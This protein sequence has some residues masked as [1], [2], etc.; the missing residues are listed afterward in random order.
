MFLA[1]GALAVI[2]KTSDEGN[3][4]VTVDRVESIH[5]T[6]EIAQVYFRKI[7]KAAVFESKEMSCLK[8]AKTIRS[9]DQARVT[10]VGRSIIGLEVGDKVLISKQAEIKRT[11]VVFGSAA[12]LCMLASAVLFFL[13]RSIR[14]RSLK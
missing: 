13:G 12:S 9:D 1:I 4:R 11:N 7:Q 14:R 8:M 10:T 6:D 2:A 3:Q 5:C